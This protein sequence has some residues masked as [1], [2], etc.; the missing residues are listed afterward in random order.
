MPKLR[1]LTGQT[2]KDVF[3][4]SRA[5]NRRV[6]NRTTFVMWNCI[7]LLC[8][9]KFVSKGNNITSGNTTSCGC[10]NKQR[11]S[12]AQLHDLT[13][14]VYGYLTVKERAPDFVR[15]D[16]Q[17]RTAWWCKC[18]CGNRVIVT[19]EHLTTGMTKSCGCYAIEYRSK[20]YTHDLTG[21]RYNHLLVIRRVSKPGQQVKW[22]CLC[23]CGNTVIVAAASLEK[24]LTQSCGCKKYSIGAEKVARELKDNNIKYKTEYKFKDLKSDKNRYLR[25]DFALIDNKN[26][27]IALIEYQGQQHFEERIN[28]DFGKYQREVSDPMKREYCK[29]HNILLFEIT[30]KDDIEFK[31]NEILL[32]LGL[33]HANPVPSPVV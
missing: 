22:K 32:S 3:V 33:K 18:I 30:Y 28:P 21:N 17:R 20:R 9:N 29:L 6:S 4:E 15:P 7:C 11:V 31:V 5:P 12:K 23:D 24:G 1:D 14:N 13:G 16:E 25:F 26:N 10:T 19:A 27:L 2:F 8:G